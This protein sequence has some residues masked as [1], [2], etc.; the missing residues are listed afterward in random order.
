MKQ[1]PRRMFTAEYKFEA[2]KLA[3]AVGVPTAARQLDVDTKSLYL[4]IR[5]TGP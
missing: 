5:P 1:I 4:W 2:V 3:G